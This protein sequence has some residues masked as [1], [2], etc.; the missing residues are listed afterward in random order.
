MTRRR[1]SFKKKGGPK[2][3]QLF[4]WVMDTPAWRD[5]DTTARSLYLEL[6]R[7]YSGTNNGSVGLGCRQ[8]AEALGVHYST[9]S[10]AFRSLCEHGFIVPVTP[11]RF[12]NGYHL[13][14]EWLLTEYFDNQT[15]EPA[16][17]DFLK[18][19]ADSQPTRSTKIK[20]QVAKSEREVAP[21]QPVST[22]IPQIEPD[23]CT[24]A[25]E[26]PVSSKSRLHPRNTLTSSHRQGASGPTRGVPDRDER[27]N[28]GAVRSQT[29]TISKEL[30]Q[31]R[32]V[33]RL[34]SG[35]GVS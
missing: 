9:A 14:T 12:G 34:R 1:N 22:I 23:S 5:L 11:G 29:I 25:T 28:Q 24:S 6:K 16:R 17:K 30:A 20:T 33:S 26:T 31:T 7:H 10:R 18:W 19:S 15:G 13:A 2:F 32:L 3:V 27:S 8:A 35:G 4:H 21:A